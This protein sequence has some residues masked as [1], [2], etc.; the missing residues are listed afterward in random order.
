MNQPIKTL[1][2][3]P[4]IGPSQ[5]TKPRSRRWLVLTTILA[6]LVVAG[7]VWWSKQVGAPE[8]AGRNRN[9]GPKSIVPEVVG[10]GDIGINLNALGTVTSLATVTVRTQISGYLQKIDFTEGN[11]VKKGDQIGRAHV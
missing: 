4:L 8:P 11:E 2:E 3:D 1:K 5:T 7:I 9:A 6:V 10:K